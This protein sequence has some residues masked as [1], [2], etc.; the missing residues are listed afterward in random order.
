MHDR[1]LTLLFTVAAV[2]ALSGCARVQEP[3]MDA[4]G[5]EAKRK[6]EQPRSDAK[7]HELR[8]RLVLTQADH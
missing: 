3:W 5:E 8:D 4:P 1:I 6:W 2:T 7:L